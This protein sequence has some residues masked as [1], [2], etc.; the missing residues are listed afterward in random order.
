[1]KNDFHYSKEMSVDPV[2]HLNAMETGAH[3]N[4]SFNN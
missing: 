3:F 4:Y 1:M 2:S